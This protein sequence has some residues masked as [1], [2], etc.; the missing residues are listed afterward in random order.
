MLYMIQLKSGITCAVI[1]TTAVKSEVHEYE[2]QRVFYFHIHVTLVACS[3]FDF[4]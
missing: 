2:W 3:P 1:I 4:Q